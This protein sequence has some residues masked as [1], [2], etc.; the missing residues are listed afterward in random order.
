MLFTSYSLFTVLLVTSIFIAVFIIVTSF[1]EVVKRIP[2]WLVYAFI[3]VIG[4]RLLLP[5]EFS[6]TKV[7]NSSNIMPA[8]KNAATVP[9]LTVSDSYN[10]SLSKSF[11][12]VWLIGAVIIFCVL[13]KEYYR[14][15]FN[16]KNIKH[17]NNNDVDKA[18]NSAMNTLNLK[19][20]PVIVMN[21][22]VAAPA[23]VGF[24]KQTIFINEYPYTEKELYYILLHE[25]THFKIKTNWMN[26][27]TAV[28]TSLFWWNPLMYWFRNHIDDLM[29]I[30]VDSYVAKKF[31]FK[32]KCEYLDCLYLV[33]SVVNSTVV[34][35]CPMVHTM[36]K[37]AKNNILIKRFNVI[38]SYK[39]VNLSM[40]IFIFLMLVCYINFAGKYVIQPFSNPPTEELEDINDV[41]ESNSF[42]IEENGQYSLYYNGELLA[43]S[44]DYEILEKTLNG[45][46]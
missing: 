5:A 37:S 10:I 9:V 24:F 21:K 26:L 23:E 32:E 20:K 13:C 34:P 3:S 17:L 25:L 4:I 27:F 22:G 29:E 31:T 43:Q 6:F 30:Y 18:L 46:K 12:F 19:N 39:K 42:I 36:A 40:C 16:L 44:D 33:S 1:T 28:L 14:L 7:I 45:G 11:Y 35:Q 15:C 2:L 41:N 8:L 38:T